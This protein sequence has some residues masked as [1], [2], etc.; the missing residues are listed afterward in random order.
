M[1]WVEALT[2]E[3]VQLWSSQLEKPGIVATGPLS[4]SLSLLLRSL[5]HF[6]SF[7]LK[8]ICVV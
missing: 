8:A 2:V 3:A 7:S 6:H 1:D 4:F 5:S